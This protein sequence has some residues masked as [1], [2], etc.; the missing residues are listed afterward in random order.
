M[1]VPLASIMVDR[2]QKWILSFFAMSQNHIRQ[3]ASSS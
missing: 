1:D 2:L 3:K